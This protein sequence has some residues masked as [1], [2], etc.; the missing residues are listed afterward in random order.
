MPPLD[1]RRDEIPLWANYMVNRRHRERL[2]E[3]QARLSAE[4]QRRLSASR[5]PGN[6]RQLDNI[7]RRAYTLAMVDHG[8]SRD[9]VL[10]ERHVNQALV[11]E[12]GSDSTSLLKALRTAAQAFFQEARRHQEPPLELDLADAFRGFVLGVAF[13]QVGREETLRL[14]GLETAVKNRNHHRIL[15]REQDRVEALCKAL[16][17]KPD[18]IIEELKLGEEG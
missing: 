6:L 9:L 8:G 10:E 12:Q 15:R 4:A 13:Q 11:F 18:P 16:G 1:D 5:W 3:G 14:F 17:V 7:I 2:P